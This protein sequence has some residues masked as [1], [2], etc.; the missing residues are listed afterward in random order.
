MLFG[1]SI[2]PTKMKVN[3]DGSWTEVKLPEQMM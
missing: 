3:R 1:D 2:I